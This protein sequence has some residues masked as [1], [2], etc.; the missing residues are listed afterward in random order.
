MCVM[1]LCTRQI[2]PGPQGPS[3]SLTTRREDHAWSAHPL[4]PLRWTAL[5]RRSPSFHRAPGTQ[6]DTGG[7]WPLGRSTAGAEPHCGQSSETPT[8]CSSSTSRDTLTRG[9]WQAGA[10][11]P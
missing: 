10:P 6:W 5:P 3:L 8:T 7:L 9:R 1:L 11:L 4:R 2:S